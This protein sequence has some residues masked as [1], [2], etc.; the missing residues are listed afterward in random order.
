MS[1]PHIPP[2]RPSPALLSPRDTR[3]LRAALG[4][5]TTGVTVIA[6][7]DPAGQPVGV[8]ANSFSSVSLD[9]PLVLFSLGRKALSLDAFLANPFFTVSV[10]SDR[11]VD[12]AGRFARTNKDKWQ[13]IDYQVW[14]SGCPLLPGSAALFECR[15][16]ATHRGGDH[17]IFLGEVLRL[18]HDPAATPLV[19]QRGGYGI[20]T[21][22]Q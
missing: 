20:F 7:L 10:L 4:S 3:D 12:I 6:T 5:F 11:Q 17:E 2:T 22:A 21:G 19:F 14:E 16:T 18:H 9:P 8:T 15:V 1:Q 13:G